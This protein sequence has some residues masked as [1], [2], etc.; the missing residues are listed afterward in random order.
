MS[1][2][3]PDF[4]HAASSTFE[5]EPER[6]R[7]AKRA[8]TSEDAAISGG[9]VPTKAFAP[10][11]HSH[12][13]HERLSDADIEKALTRMRYKRRH[14]WRSDDRER[15]LSLSFLAIQQQHWRTK[16]SA[17]RDQSKSKMHIADQMPQ[18]RSIDAHSDLL[19]RYRNLQQQL[20]KWRHLR[21]SRDKQE[22]AL[23]AS[24]QRLH[25]RGVIDTVPSLQQLLSVHVP[26]QRHQTTRHALRHS[27]ALEDLSEGMRRCA[28]QRDVGNESQAAES[29]FWRWMVTAAKEAETAQNELQKSTESRETTRTDGAAEHKHIEADEKMS[30]SIAAAAEL[31]PVVHA[32]MAGGAL[33]RETWKQTFVETRDRLRAKGIVRCTDRPKQGPS[34]EKT[35]G[36]RESKASDALEMAIPTSTPPKSAQVA[37]VAI[38]DTHRKALS[39]AVRASQTQNPFQ[40]VITDVVGGVGVKM[41]RVKR[42]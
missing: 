25:E 24:A 28:R 15:L 11:L 6:L 31:E 14:L 27:N 33:D 23:L 16:Y 7:L 10:M 34:H 29:K 22:R 20:Q 26:E 41:G 3:I 1:A 8:Q 37:L 2:P 4:I 35:Q 13:K 32:M 30:A 12:D 19:L 39:A 21:S 9:V 36:M 18:R 17:S 5:L 38:R 40:C 42:A